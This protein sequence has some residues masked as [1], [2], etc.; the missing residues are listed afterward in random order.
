MSEP[1]LL[2]RWKVPA[3]GRSPPCPGRSRWCRRCPPRPR[4]CPPVIAAGAAHGPGPDEV[5][6]AIQ[7]GHENVRAAAAGEVEGARPRVE[8]HRAREAPGGVDV[9]RPVQGDAIP[10]FKRPPMALAQTKLP[11]LSSLDTKMSSNHRAGEVEGARP[12]VEVRRAREA[13][14]WCRRC[15]LRPR[16]CHA[17]HR[18]WCRPWPWPTR[19]CPRYPAWT[20][21]CRSLPL[22]VRLKV[23]GPGSKSA[24]PWK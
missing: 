20:R 6:L 1:P 16:R 4:R 12:R 7:L 23:P 18:R 21:K 17:Q 10:P 22:L 5:A 14:R 2:V 9:A 19:S 11:A 3:P 13:N 15:P 24:V 8:V